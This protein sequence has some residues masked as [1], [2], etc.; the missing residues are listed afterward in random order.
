VQDF[1]SS[2]YGVSE[3]AMEKGGV[4]WTF[5]PVRSLPPLMNDFIIIIY[6][7]C[8]F[9]SLDAAYQAWPSP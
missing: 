6:L 2:L 5:P 3:L 9:F 7:F 1:F 4:F 8:Y